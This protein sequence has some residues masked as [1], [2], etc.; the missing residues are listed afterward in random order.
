MKAKP[1]EVIGMI[2]AL[3]FVVLLLV[4]LT[5]KEIFSDFTDEKYG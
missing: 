4:V 1:M 2:L 3:P 5:A